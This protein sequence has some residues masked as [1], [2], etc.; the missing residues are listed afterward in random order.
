MNAELSQ[1][2]IQKFEELMQ[3]TRIKS[4]PARY[5][6]QPR[7]ENIASPWKF[8]GVILG[9]FLV[10]KVKLLVYHYLTETPARGRGFLSKTPPQPK[11]K[12]RHCPEYNFLLRNIISI[13]HLTEVQNYN[14]KKI[15]FLILTQ[16]IAFNLMLANAK[17][18][19]LLFLIPKT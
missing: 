15:F 13:M 17:N 6:P 11:F 3:E 19:I 18:P 4:K 9:G 14:M 8:S 7:Q 16:I 1:L 5:F 10:L 12:L 2:L